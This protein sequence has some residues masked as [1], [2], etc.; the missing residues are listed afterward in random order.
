MI[1]SDDTKMSG[2]DSVMNKIRL[3]VIGCGVMGNRHIASV[4]SGK[5]PDMVIGALC[6]NSSEKLEA[7]KAKYPDVMQRICSKVVFVIPY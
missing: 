1:V 3:G 4:M 2:K 5:V 7:V 6:D